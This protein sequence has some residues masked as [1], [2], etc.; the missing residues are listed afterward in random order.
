MASCRVVA[1]CRVVIDAT[2]RL[3]DAACL[4]TRPP[5]ALLPHACKHRCMRTPNYLL[6]PRSASCPR[7]VLPCAPGH[8]A[9]VDNGAGTEDEMMGAGGREHRRGLATFVF[10]P[11]EH[12]HDPQHVFNKGAAEV[13]FFMPG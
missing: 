5:P 6:L 7:D 9:A 1:G 2:A 11:W 4:P 3:D 13:D 12:V 8:A 10:V